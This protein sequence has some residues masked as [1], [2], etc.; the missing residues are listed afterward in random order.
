MTHYFAKGFAKSRILTVKSIAELKADYRRI[1]MI[2]QRF[3]QLKEAHNEPNKN[4]GFK[5]GNQTY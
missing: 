4:G 2:D 3:E 5:N 1:C